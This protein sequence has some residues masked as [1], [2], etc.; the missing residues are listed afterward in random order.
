MASAY[1]GCK[2]G[3]RMGSDPLV[4]G[5]AC[6]ANASAQVPSTFEVQV[7]ELTLKLESWRKAEQKFEAADPDE[8]P[9]P[10]WRVAGQALAF[11]VLGSLVVLAQSSFKFVQGFA[12]RGLYMSLLVICG[13]A[14]LVLVLHAMHMFERRYWRAFF[15]PFRSKDNYPFTP[16]IRRNERDFLAI[17][18]LETFGDVVVS[19]VHERLGLLES[20]LSQRLTLLGGG[21]AFPAIVGFATTIWSGFKSLQ[22]ERSIIS[23]AALIGAI[24]VMLLTGYAFRLRFSVFELTRCRMLLALEISRR[25]DAIQSAGHGAT[26]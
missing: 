11:L 23:I 21:T 7:T 19:T 3:T 2:N 16:L 26:R 20:E 17:R 6:S 14:A 25:R 9:D 8:M 4:N 18:D 13:G 10:D 22:V 12:T 5:L 24:L 15:S 1:L